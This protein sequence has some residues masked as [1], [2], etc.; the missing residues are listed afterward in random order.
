MF[1]GHVMLKPTSGIFV[2]VVIVRHG[3]KLGCPEA[4]AKVFWILEAKAKA[5]NLF[6]LEAE[7]RL[8]KILEAEAEALALKKRASCLVHDVWLLYHNKLHTEDVLAWVWTKFKHYY[9]NYG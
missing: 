8:S 1:M 9:W 3:P 4:E 7:A 2:A 6:K 5:L